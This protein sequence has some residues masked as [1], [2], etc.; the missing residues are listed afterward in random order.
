MVGQAYD[1]S[2][3]TAQLQSNLGVYGSRVVVIVEQRELGEVFRFE[4]GVITQDS[5]IGIASCTKWLSGAVT[6]LACA[7]RGLFHLDDR[8]GDHLPVFNANGK[9]GITIRQCFGMKSR[10][11]PAGPGL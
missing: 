1:F 2:A 10:T 9:G 5:K 6:V 7:E 4:S 8:I 11:L 3:A